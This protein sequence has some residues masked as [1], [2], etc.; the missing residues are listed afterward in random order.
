MK[1]VVNYLNFVFHIV[2]KTK[3]NDKFLNFVFQFIKNMKWHFGY[4]DCSANLVQLTKLLFSFFHHLPVGLIL[5][6]HTLGPTAL[7]ETQNIAILK[8]CNQIYCFQPLVFMSSS[9]NLK[10]KIIVTTRVAF[11]FMKNFK[12]NH[13]IIIRAGIT[14]KKTPCYMRD[15]AC[16]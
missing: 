8:K 7:N 14:C 2:V 9:Q 15:S 13:R 12:T 5:N 1:I 16:R 11:T 10:H 6:C 4:T 3:F